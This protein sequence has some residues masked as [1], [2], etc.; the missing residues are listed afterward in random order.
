V[1]AREDVQM[2]LEAPPAPTVT[3]AAPPLVLDAPAIAAPPPRMAPQP[4]RI[5]RTWRSLAWTSTFAASALG[6]AAIVALGYRQSRFDDFQGDP[7]CFVDVDTG[8]PVGGTSCVSAHGA[9]Q[10]AGV[11]AVVT[12][13]AAGVFAAG[14][15]V[16]WVRARGVARAE[17]AAAW[18]CLPAPAGAVCAGRF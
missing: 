17:S 2:R 18:S 9:V 8:L 7:G 11:A 13:V 5:D 6:A 12:S 10:S 14:A 15:V 4:P 3:V 1:V 16:A